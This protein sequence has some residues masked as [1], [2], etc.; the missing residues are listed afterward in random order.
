MSSSVRFQVKDILHPCP[1]QVLCDLY[2]ESQLEGEVILVT[3]KAEKENGYL[4]IQVPG[5]SEPVLVPVRHTA[6]IPPDEPL[7]VPVQDVVP[8]G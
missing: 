8:P 5:L 4:V 2:G 1:V 6:S 7:L 3:G